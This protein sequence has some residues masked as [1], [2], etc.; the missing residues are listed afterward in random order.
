MEHESKQDHDTLKETLESYVRYLNDGNF[1]E[2]LNLWE[3]N[4][5]QMMAFVPSVEGKDAIRKVM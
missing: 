1:K 5:V 3:E 2:W 4:G